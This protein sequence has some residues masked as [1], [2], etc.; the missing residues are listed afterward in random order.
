MQ[1]QHR[2]EAESE[3]HKIIMLKLSG[4]QTSPGRHDKWGEAFAPEMCW[5]LETQLILSSSLINLPTTK[6]EVRR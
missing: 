4:P 5:N 6:H 1:V 2:R 3:R